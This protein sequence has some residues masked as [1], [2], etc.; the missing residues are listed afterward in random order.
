[1]KKLLGII[2]I[3]GF[4]MYGLEIDSSY[5]IELPRQEGYLKVSNKHEIFYSLFGNPQGIP[6]VILHG[7][8]GMGCSSKNC[9]F[10]DL[11]KFNVIIFD[12]RGA[13]RSKPFAC[14]EENTTQNLIQDL[15]K[16]RRFLSIEKWVVFGGSWG[17][18]LGIL[19]GEEHPDSCLGFVL[20]GI[21]LGR[22]QDIQLFRKKGTAYLEFISLFSEDEKKDLLA[23][24]YLRIMDSD[25]KVHLPLARAFFRYIMSSTIY[26]NNQAKVESLSEDDRLV[27]S[28]TRAVFYYAMN[29]LFIS[30]NQAILQINKVAHLPAFIIQGSDDLNCPSEQAELLHQ[31][32]KN[33]HLKI[34]NGSGHSSDDSAMENAIIEAI[35]CF[36]NIN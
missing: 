22:E 11:H 1:M 33:S 2:L 17:S 30:P 35:N 36:T 12:Q 9:R 4:N 18:L 27:L 28:M 6:V 10:F 8:P 23:S 3:L 19:Y 24:C 16:L 20:S 29:H 7:G 32:W 14:M 21:F 31:H 15:E 5:P 13:M 34:I 26:T 25:E